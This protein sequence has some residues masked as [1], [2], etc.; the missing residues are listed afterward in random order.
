MTTDDEVEGYNIVKA[1]CREVVDVKRIAIRDTKSYCGILLDN[2]N[3][4]PYVGSGSTL[5]G[6][7][8]DS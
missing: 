8:S 1:I 2:N 5:P 4:S 7:T 6:S 3:A